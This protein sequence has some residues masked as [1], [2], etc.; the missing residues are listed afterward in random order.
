MSIHWT[1]PTGK[2]HLDSIDKEHSM[3]EL[4]ELLST[5]RER[6]ERL[7]QLE[8]IATIADKIQSIYFAETSGFYHPDL[9]KLMF[10]LRA[11]LKEGNNDDGQADT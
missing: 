10:Q 6:F 9:N 11:S 4:W 2:F 1:D 3:P 7:E 5:I 8:E